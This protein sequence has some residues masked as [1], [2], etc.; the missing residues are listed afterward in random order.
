LKLIASTFGELAN[1]QGNSMNNL[2]RELFSLRRLGLTIAIF[3]AASSAWGQATVTGMN[4]LSSTRVGRTTYDYT[5]TINVTNGSPGLSN[6]VATVTSN[7]AA[8]VIVQGSVSLGTLAAGASTTSTNTFTLQQDRLVPFNP[9]ALSWTITGTPF[10]VVP[11]VVNLTQGAASAAI[12]GAGLTVGTVS[13]ASSS[14]VA[15]GSVISQSPSA[16]ASAAPGSAV[17][18]VVSSGPASVTVPSV[19][20]LTQAAASA[21]IVGAGLTV[22][23]VTTAGSSSVASGS[24]ISQNPSAG[25]S[26]ASGSTVNLTLSTGPVLVS[27]PIVTGLS[28]TAASAAISGAGLVVG[29]VSSQSSSSVPSGEVISE[30]P[31]A[32]TL[33]DVGSAVSFVVSTG[34][35]QVTVPNVVG[36]SQASATTMITGDSLALGNVSTGSSATIVAGDVISE[37][38]SA[39][40]SVSPGTT[41]SLIVSTGPPTV[42]VPNVVS[43]TQASAATAVVG[44]GLIVG[45]VTSQSSTSV[46]V[47]VVISE[48]PLAGTL[49]VD[50]SAVNLMVSTGPTAYQGTLLPGNPSSPAIGATTTFGPIQSSPAAITSSGALLDKIDV[51]FDPSATVGQINA[52]IESVNGSISAMRAGAPGF[53]LQ[54][55]IA[56]DATTLTQ[57]A[58]TL[59][60]QPG[61]VGAR[62][63]VMQ[64]PLSIPLPYAGTENTQHLA[65][66]RFPAAFSVLSNPSLNLLTQCSGPSSINVIV[67]DY[68][69]FDPNLAT[70]DPDSTSARLDFSA[71]VP[72]F[73][74]ETFFNEDGIAVSNQIANDANSGGEPT[75]GA[76][77]TMTLAGVWSAGGVAGT[78]LLGAAPA[79]VTV[80]G[81]NIALHSTK[82]VEIAV[83]DVAQPLIDSTGQSV[84][85]NVS[86]GYYNTCGESDGNALPCTGLGNTLAQPEYIGRAADR[87]KD[88]LYWRIMNNLPLQNS[89]SEFYWQRILGVAAAGNSAT[90][91]AAVLYP[92]AGDAIANSFLT[93]AGSATPMSTLIQNTSLWNPTSFLGLG[94]PNL[95]ATSCSVT[96]IPP[97]ELQIVQNLEANLGFNVSQYGS[98]IVTGALQPFVPPPG[99]LTPKLD[100]WLATVTPWSFSSAFST[101]YSVY[102]VGVGVAG[103]CPVAEDEQDDSYAPNQCAIDTGTSITAPQVSGL[104]AMLWAVDGALIGPL[105]QGNAATLLSTTQ[106]SNTVFLISSTAR[107]LAAAV[108]PNNQAIDALAAMLSLDMPEA[109]TPATAPVR[110]H[111]LDQDGNGTFDQNDVELFILNYYEYPSKFEA[112]QP[113]PGAAPDFSVSDLNGDGYTGAW[114]T[115]TFD[116]DPTGSTQYGAPLL[117]IV[118]EKLLDGHTLH[119]DENAV[120]DLDVMCYY[121]YSGLYQGTDTDGHIRAGLGCDAVV[122]MAESGDTLSGGSD[123]TTLTQIIESIDSKVSV[124]KSGAIAFSVSNTNNSGAGA[125]VNAAH[126][127]YPISFGPSTTRTYGG[128]SMNDAPAGPQAAFEDRFSGAPPSFFVRRWQADG[129]AVETDIGT[130]PS[131][132]FASALSYVDMNDAGVV[133]FPSLDPTFSFEQLMAGNGGGLNTFASFADNAGTLLRP[134]IASNNFVVYAN[135]SGGIVVTNALTNATAL[136]AQPP[137]ITAVSD[138]PGISA[139]GNW[140]AFG[141]T[142]TNLGPALL[143]SSATASGSSSPSFSAPVAVL[144]AGPGGD[145]T[146]NAQFNSFGVRP[147]AGS[148][149][150]RFG[151]ATTP[152]PGGSGTNITIVFVASRSYLD[153]TTHAVTKTVYGVYHL[154]AIATGSGNAAAYTNVQIDPIVEVGDVLPDGA[155]VSRTVA[156]FDLWDPVSKNGTYAGFWV[157]F[158]ETLTSPSVPIQAVV[159]RHL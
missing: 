96:T 26:A 125:R 14:S 75:H 57:T 152:T 124:N 72:R 86:L 84:I 30:G 118:S 121:A 12:T 135:P 108:S 148:D 139:D 47:G 63:G 5:Y 20:N 133:V 127:P 16:G 24:V 45:T 13:S 37:S 90:T 56:P 51:D 104:A 103:S 95:V 126:L 122:I 15:S 129:T 4:Q 150:T 149:G 89:P 110:L 36:L 147:S 28:R 94:Y 93:L 91:P 114:T 106:V 71:R 65:A 80:H 97:C 98:T 77:I 10:D 50:G 48:S 81:I 100:Q 113:Q 157:Q 7:A 19:V 44:A 85:L 116:L 39:G 105:H 117:N 131:G 42:A 76:D 99:T 54:V 88:A 41:V 153:P 82:D 59:S 38:P 78:G 31:P 73:V 23:S 107:P 141:G 140:V 34:P 68:F 111:L 58:Q 143:I 138:R 146:P 144:F 46:A 62:M 112:F 6:A 155:G 119:F 52:A 142:L 92:G 27:V 70:D 3:V 1:P 18:L 130:S 69:D 40:T 136:V 128:A 154:S 11:S 21:A 158:L 43:L 33:V 22:G 101:D 134:Q 67:A 145:P 53:V 115:T 120:T 74:L 109:V 35:A 25:A 151:I 79:C 83:A 32:G 64:K 132:A 49:V 60:Q 17:I 123:G 159:R 55:P 156:D 137:A 61:I 66:A 8:T 87:A 2:S 29:A 102:A 9:T